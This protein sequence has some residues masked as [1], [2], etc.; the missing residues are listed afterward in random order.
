MIVVMNLGASVED[1]QEV[2]EKITQFGYSVHRSTGK[3]RTILGAIGLPREEVKELLEGIPS[4]EKVVLVSSPYK[5]VSREFK[6]E[7]TV[8]KVGDVEIGGDK[9]VLIAGPCAVERRS[10]LQAAEAVKKAGADILRGGAYKPRS[11]PYS[12]QGLEE[13]G[14]KIMAE[15]RELTGLPLITEV[16]DQHS[17]EIVAKYVDIIQVGAR[18]MQN[19][20]LLKELGQLDKPVLLKRGMSAT[21]EEWL[22]AA[23][24]LLSSGNERVIL[25]ER[26]IRTFETYTRNTLDISAVPVAKELSHLP[27]FVDPSHGTGKW[28][29]VPPMSLAAIAAGADG[30]LIEVHPFPEEALCDGSQSLVP[31]K[32]LQMIEPLKGVAQTV[33]RTL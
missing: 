25:C 28:K 4:V 1:I 32:F 8:F 9:I 16:L 33:G 11:S 12:F 19:F 26:G 27:V 29:W 15:A 7:R 21:I 31:Q 30:L 10:F 18:N 6:K 3:K 14:L 5:L 13:E 24:Y 22:M 23:E 17:I 2:E 20:K